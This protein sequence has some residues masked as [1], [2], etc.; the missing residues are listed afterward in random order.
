MLKRFGRQ[1]RH[2]AVCF[3]YSMLDYR[4]ILDPLDILIHES[5]TTSSSCSCFH[6]TVGCYRLKSLKFPRM[7]PQVLAQTYVSYATPSSPSL[8]TVSSDSKPDVRPY[9]R[10]CFLSLLAESRSQS[11][12]VNAPQQSLLELLTRAALPSQASREA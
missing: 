2:F 3:L 5:P 8:L 1:G 4:Y 9:S 11:H 12:R 6:H 7:P 10:Q